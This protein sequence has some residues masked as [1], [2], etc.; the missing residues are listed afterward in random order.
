MELKLEEY[1]ADTQSD[2]DPDIDSL[3]YDEAIKLLLNNED[4]LY[5]EIIKIM[6]N[7][8][9]NV[10]KIAN[11]ILKRHKL[12]RYISSSE[13]QKLT[14]KISFI[15]RTKTKK[16]RVYYK[17]SSRKTRRLYS[18]IDGGDHNVKDI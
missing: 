4:L 6:G 16:F 14:S 15:L 17:N 10:H 11:N 7:R 9:M 1:T 13:Y 3:T 2:G 18:I 12:K 8:Q 5:R